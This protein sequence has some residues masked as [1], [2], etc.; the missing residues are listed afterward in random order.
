MTVRGRWYISARAVREYAAI[1]GLPSDD[2]DFPAR[3]RELLELCATAHLVR[4]QQNGLEQ[5]RSG[6]P[7]R[8]RL[9]VSPAARPEGP[10]P[11]LVSVLASHATEPRRRPR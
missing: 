8:L 7:L 9:M 3:E 11:Q 2:N 4:R 6:R 10:L 1:A 5:W